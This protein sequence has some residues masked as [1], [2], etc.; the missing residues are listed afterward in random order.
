MFQVVTLSVVDLGVAV[1]SVAILGVMP[2]S[3]HVAARVRQGRAGKNRRV[4]EKS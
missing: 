1:L 4:V 2:P 3:Y